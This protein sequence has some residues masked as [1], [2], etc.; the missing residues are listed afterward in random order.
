MRLARLAPEWESASTSVLTTKSKFSLT[1]LG[2][3]LLE[4]PE[5]VSYVWEDTLP[6]GGISILVAKPKVG[7]STLA[8]NL[9]LS[10]AR[11]QGLLGR[12]TSQGS[13]VYF[14]IEE[15]RAQVQDHFARMGGSE[16]DDIFIHVGSAPDEALQELE[17]TINQHRPAL[18]HQAPAI[19]HTGTDGPG[20][21]K[22]EGVE[23]EGG[24]H[25]FNPG[26]SH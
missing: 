3:L 20:L 2:D 6:V 13:V 19:L 12:N 23:Q 21:G 8:R 4:D 24:G 11:G 9:A 22:W 15:K 5:E 10:V 18:V 14:A 16:A 1:K 17:N 7:K 25:P 26:P